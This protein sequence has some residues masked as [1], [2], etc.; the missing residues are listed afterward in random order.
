MLTGVGFYF[1]LTNGSVEEHWVFT[2]KGNHT[3]AQVQVLFLTQK[4]KTPN[5]KL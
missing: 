4:S 5:L 3:R 1:S 2:G